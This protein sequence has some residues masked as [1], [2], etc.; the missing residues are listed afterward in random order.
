MPDSFLS[1][2]WHS[3]HFTLPPGAVS[4]A[5]SDPTPNQAYALP[6]LKIVGLQ[7]HPEHTLAMVEFFTKNYG[8]EWR[9]GPYVKPWA[10]TLEQ[11]KTLPDTYELMD[12]LLGNMLARFG[13]E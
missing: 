10:E 3:D 11:T 9:T 8:P 12:A 7:F 2:H 6:D 5:Q 1:F 4:L 13:P